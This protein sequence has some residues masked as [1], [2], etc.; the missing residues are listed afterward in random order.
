L[1]VVSCGEFV[2]FG[3]VKVVRRRG[4]VDR[5]QCSNRFELPFALIDFFQDGRLREA[6]SGTV[7]R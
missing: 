6:A 2:V 3:V 1:V 5:L 4:S 7:E